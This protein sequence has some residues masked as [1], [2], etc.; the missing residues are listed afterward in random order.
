M[1]MASAPDTPAAIQSLSTQAEQLPSVYDEPE[2]LNVTE[3]PVTVT[4][5]IDAQEIERTTARASRVVNGMVCVHMFGRN[6]VVLPHSL[7]GRVLSHYHDGHAHPSINKT[8]K[9]IS[10]FYWWPA[11]GRDIKQ[12]VESCEICQIVKRDSRPPAGEMQ[13]MPAA[14][15]PLEMLG[16]DSV[17]LGTSARNTAHKLIHVIIDHHSRFV[18][19]FASKGQTTIALIQA[20]DRVIRSTGPRLASRDGQLSKFP[21]QSLQKVLEGQHHRPPPDVS[22]TIRRPMAWWSA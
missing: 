22:P 3:S 4:D 13:L 2:S 10:T 17:V 16:M 21:I 5:I 12:Y 19:A 18:W 9:L 6:R 8:S 14:S 1:A 11:M 15:L 20:L 7:V